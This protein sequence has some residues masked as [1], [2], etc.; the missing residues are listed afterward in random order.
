MNGY[1]DS[2]FPSLLP[3]LPPHLV[4]DVLHNN[5]YLERKP[6]GNWVLKTKPGNYFD[7]QKEDGDLVAQFSN[8]NLKF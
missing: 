6:T 2:T 8:K 4:A 7:P 5:K 3:R 1:F